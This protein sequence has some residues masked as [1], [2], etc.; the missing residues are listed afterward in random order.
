MF[1]TIKLYLLKKLLSSLYLKNFNSEV[2]D[3]SKLEES[4]Q[5]DIHFLLVEEIVYKHHG[6]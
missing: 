3:L 6:K 1:T 4:I 5:D 2:H